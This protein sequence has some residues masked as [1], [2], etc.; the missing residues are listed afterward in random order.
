MTKAITHKHLHLC[1]NHVSL[2]AV[3]YNLQKILHI[4]VVS[5]FIFL[6]FSIFFYIIYLNV[7]FSYMLM[8]TSFFKFNFRYATKEKCGMRRMSSEVS[9]P[10]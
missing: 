4:D 9:Q 8:L 5:F 10:G 1:Q 3:I 2:T 7:Y 6:Y